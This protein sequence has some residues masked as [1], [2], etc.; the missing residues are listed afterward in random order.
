MSRVALVVGACPVRLWNLDAETRIRR[1][2]EQVGDVSLLSNAGAYPTGADLLLLNAE[3]LFEPY[4][5]EALLEKPGSLLTADG[6]FAAAFAP[7]NQAPALL[8]DVQANRLPDDTAGLT[9]IGTADLARYDRQ[10]RKTKPPLLER[11][12]ADRQAE[13]ESLLYGSAYKGITDLVTKFVWPKPAR[14]GVRGCTLAGLSPNIVT[15]FGFLLMLYACY[16][17]LNGDY[18][19]GLLAGWIMT[20]LD[21]VDGKLARVTVTSSRFGHV[22]DHG[23]DILHP[24]FWYVFWGMSLAAYQPWH[25]LSLETMYWLVIG[26]YIGGR[27]CEAAFHLLGDASIFSWRPIDAYFRLIT[28]RRNPCMIL[29][30]VGVLLGRPDWAF[31]WVVFWTALTTLLLVLRLLYGTGVRIKD[32][33]LQPWLKDAERAAR[34]HPAAFRTF[35]GTQGAY[36]A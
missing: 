23:M 3:F 4:T 25:G 29:M 24:P 17:F 28:G 22:L 19:T 7:A 34:E 9:P 35:S 18:A 30:T 15:G 20:Y 2:L 13:L 31:D 8:Q 11:V 12:S 6:A 21:T 33:P 1:Q 26:G 32:G 16:A 5:I 14:V 36:D 27:L 10:L